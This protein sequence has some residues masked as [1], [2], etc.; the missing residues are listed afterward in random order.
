M[1]GEIT[2]VG[3]SLASLRDSGKSKLKLLHLNVPLF[4]KYTF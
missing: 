4:Q 1:R 3:L 2:V